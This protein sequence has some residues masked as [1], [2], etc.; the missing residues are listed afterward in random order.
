MSS[1]IDDVEILHFPAENR[2]VIRRDGAEAELVYRIDKDRMLIVH[3]EVP[4]ALGG[5][6]IGAQLVNAAVRRAAAEDLTVVPWCPFARRYLRR[7][8]DEAASVTVDWTPPPPTVPAG[9]EALPARPELADEHLDEEEEESF[10]ASDPHSDWAG[11][12]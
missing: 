9:G 4:D 6:G 8:P 11:P 10:P 1:P 7:H 2:F 12:G 3:T 5:R